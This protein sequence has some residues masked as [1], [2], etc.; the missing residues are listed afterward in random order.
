MLIFENS[1]L[2]AEYP[3]IHD[4]SCLYWEA[5]IELLDVSTKLNLHEVRKSVISALGCL[6]PTEITEYRIP[7]FRPIIAGYQDQVEEKMFYRT[8]P[9]KA[10]NLFHEH[11]VPSM[12]PM[13]YYHA[14]QLSL[15]DIVN[16]VEDGGILWKLNTVDIIKV[17]KGREKLKTSRRQVLFPWLDDK[18][19]EVGRD[20][21]AGSATCERKLTL[22][23]NYCWENFMEIYSQ[24]NRSGFLDN[25]TNGLQ[26]LSENAEKIFGHYVCERCRSDA[27]RLLRAGELENWGNLP[28]YFG[29]EDWDAVKKLQENIDRGWE[30]EY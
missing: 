23:G 26:G 24:F 21:E 9:I 1:E 20:S 29:F 18:L 5:A 17:L 2:R 14:A 7:K 25:I 11:G 28:E 13:A 10:I 15:E 22:N 27:L 30:D 4:D 3:D 12:L 8:F 6:F 16:G 19:V